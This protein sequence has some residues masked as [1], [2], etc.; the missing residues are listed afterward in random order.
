MEPTERRHIQF[1]LKP[2]VLE[3][4]AEMSSCY[5]QGVQLLDKAHGIL[6]GLRESE[7][8]VIAGECVAREG[9]HSLADRTDERLVSDDLG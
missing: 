6:V 2:G 8:L 3:K 5:S 7:G 9:G 4:L 1:V